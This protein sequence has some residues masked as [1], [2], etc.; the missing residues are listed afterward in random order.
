M[1]N[2]IGR[3]ILALIALGSWIVGIILTLKWYDWKLLVIFLLFMF[4]NN[5]DNYLK[6]TREF[7]NRQKYNMFKESKKK[8]YFQERLEKM[9]EENKNKIK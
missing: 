3:L 2:L 5:L 7:H 4:A 8:S 6:M 1:K 9:A